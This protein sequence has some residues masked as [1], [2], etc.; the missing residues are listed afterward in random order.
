MALTYDGSNG[1]FTRLGKLFGL[2]DAVRTHQ[3]DIRARVAGIEA[4][5]SST[6]AWWIGPLLGRMEQRITEAGRILEDV[7][8]AATTTLV[9]TCFDESATSTRQVMARRDLEQALLFLQREMRA[10]SETIQ[11]TT[12]TIGSPT[13]GGSNVG[14]GTVVLAQLPPRRFGTNTNLPYARTELLEFRCVEDSQGLGVASGEE[15]FEMRGQPAFPNLD[16]RFPAGSG[17]QLRM[18]SVRS[19]VDAGSRYANQLTNGSFEAFTTSSP[20]SWGVVTGV[21]GTDFDQDFVTFY[22][23]TASLRLDG[24]GSTLTRIQQQLRSETGSTGA[25]VADRPFL[26]TCRARKDAGVVAGEVKVTLRDGSGTIITGAEITITTSVSSSSWDLFTAAF[27][28]P[29]DIPAVVYA[30]IRLA[31]AITSGNSVY[32]DELILCEM[33]QPTPSEPAVVILAGSTDWV[34]DD[35][36]TV[37]VANNGEGDI[38]LAMDR[39]FDLHS[40]GLPFP[41]TAGTPTILDSLVS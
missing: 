27:R 15:V 19:S 8:L 39:V 5:Y 22:R 4:E 26:L 41:D 21:A 2:M 1:L 31:T 35:S 7:R 10:D 13:A 38:Y 11:R 16:D 37:S 34:V 33:R 14:T 40:K 18:P 30:D 20:D 3:A 28:T 29:L 12:V 25:L 32:I 9:E 6:D 23:D 17:S 36:L 24:D